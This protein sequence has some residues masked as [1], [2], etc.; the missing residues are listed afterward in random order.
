MFTARS[1][2]RPPSG[3]NRGHTSHTTHSRRSSDNN[4]STALCCNS[5]LH[6]QYVF[7][8]LTPVL[9]GIH[10]RTGEMNAQASDRHFPQGVGDVRGRGLHRIEWPGIIRNLSN[11]LIFLYFDANV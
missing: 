10:Q 3:T 2:T 8:T 9:H 5:F 11:E 6:Y 7:V 4:A 1:R